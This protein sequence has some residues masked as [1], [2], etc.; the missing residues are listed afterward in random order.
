MPVTYILFKKP[1][2]EKQRSFKALSF[3]M[4]KYLFTT[5]L[6]TSEWNSS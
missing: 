6:F 2:T 4:G 3:L 5:L 1:S